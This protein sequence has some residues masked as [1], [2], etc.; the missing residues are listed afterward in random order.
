MQWGASEVSE[1][2]QRSSLLEGMPTCLIFHHCFLL[3]FENKY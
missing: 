1:K 3:L 2:K